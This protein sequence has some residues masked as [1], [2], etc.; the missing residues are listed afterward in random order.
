MKVLKNIVNSGNTKSR[1]LGIIAVLMGII[2]PITAFAASVAREDDNGYFV[3]VFL[4]LLAL[5][6]VAQIIPAV[7][8]MS[9]MAKGIE[10]AEKEEI[11]AVEK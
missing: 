5:I 8:L 9:G 3:W 7:L 10:S 2:A 4:G 6:V 11:T 1:G